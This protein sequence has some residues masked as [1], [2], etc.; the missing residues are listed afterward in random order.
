MIISGLKNTKNLIKRDLIE[1]DL[2]EMKKNTINTDWNFKS[3]IIKKLYFNVK[4]DNL[5]W[6]AR[7]R[8]SLVIKLTSLL[9]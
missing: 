1:I 9:S 7:N 3:I 8:L 6:F 4:S 5:I 2:I